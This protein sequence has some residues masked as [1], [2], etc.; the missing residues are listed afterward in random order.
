MNRS[1]R[2]TVASTRRR[3]ATGTEN[4]HQSISHPAFIGRLIDQS[5]DHLSIRYCGQRPPV[6]GEERVAMATAVNAAPF[7]PPQGQP[8]RQSLLNDVSVTS[9]ATP[10][11]LTMSVGC[12]TRYGD[13]IAPFGFEPEG[14]ACSDAGE[15]YEY[16]DEQQ[17]AAQWQGDNTQLAMTS[18]NPNYQLTSH[19]K[20]E[21]NLLNTTAS[22]PS[23][24]DVAARLGISLETDRQSVD[25]G[26]RSASG[27]VDEAMS[28]VGRRVKPETGRLGRSK[29]LP[30]ASER[31]GSQV[32]LSSVTQF[33]YFTFLFNFSWPLL[34]Q[35]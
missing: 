28:A 31:S 18:S 23:A 21:V 14:A 9:T 32:D 25:D 29:P 4:S 16:Y 26:L 13:V 6:P 7:P 10:R 22:L 3:V 33:V 27:N 34:L 20:P 15:A 1:C 12:S 8:S 30:L 2:E 24:A 11:K 35:I 19:S 5:N 17:T